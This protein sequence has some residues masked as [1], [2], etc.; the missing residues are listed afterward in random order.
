MPICLFSVGDVKTRVSLKKPAFVFCSVLV[1]GK[2]MG[3]IIS[4][5]NG[6]VL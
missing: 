2:K 5:C 3:Y 1:Y 4:H 6:R